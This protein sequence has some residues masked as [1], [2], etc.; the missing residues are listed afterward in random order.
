MMAANKQRILTLQGLRAIAFIGIF[1]SHTDITLFSSLGPWGVSIFL[2]LSGFLMMIN[3]SEEDKKEGA[4]L[5]ERLK[6]AVYRVKKLYPLHIAMMITACVFEIYNFRRTGFGLFTVKI[7]A[8]VSL[9]KSFIPNSSIYYSLNAVSWYLSL[10]IFCYFCFPWILKLFK[11]ISIKKTMLWIA[12]ILIGQTILGYMASKLNLFIGDGFTKWFVYVCPFVRIIEF[13]L[14]CLLGVIY[15]KKIYVDQRLHKILGGS[16]ILI[17]IIVNAVYIFY[18]PQD[19]DLLHPELWWRYSVIFSLPNAILIYCI[20][21]AQKGWLNKIL[22]KKE[23]TWLGDMSAYAF[24][25][26]QM[27]IRYINVVLGK[28]PALLDERFMLILKVLLSFCITII[29]CIFWNRLMVYIR[30]RKVVE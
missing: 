17:I 27:V 10:S 29:T 1:L 25:I 26:H 4:S 13:V 16:A 12:I 5:T 6:F 30:S 23:L 22:I 14:G 24:L 18:N 7:L 28:I 2:I 19:S 15:L 11:K 21:T 8:N 20:A 9:T 3:Y